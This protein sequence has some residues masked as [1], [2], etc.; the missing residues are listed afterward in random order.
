MPQPF[1]LEYLL[2]CA[3]VFRECLRQLLMALLCQVHEI[4]SFCS[5]AIMR[6]RCNP[7]P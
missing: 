6:V 7:V 1:L 5:A 3:Y 2:Y 4:T